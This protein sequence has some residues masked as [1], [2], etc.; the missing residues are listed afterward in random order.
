[1][2]FPKFNC[3]FRPSFG[4][5]ADAESE[6]MTYIPIL[7]VLD[8]YSRF[9]HGVYTPFNGGYTNDSVIFALNQES[10]RIISGEGRMTGIRHD[11]NARSR[12]IVITVSGGTV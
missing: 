2:L 10:R 1:V 5:G 4:I 7:M 11:Y 3:V 9:P 12:K 6:T 8:F